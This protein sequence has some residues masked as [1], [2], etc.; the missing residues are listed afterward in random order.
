MARRRAASLF[1]TIAHPRCVSAFI[2]S[3][4]QHEGLPF[5]QING[6]FTIGNNGEG[7]LPQVGNSFQWSDSFTKVPVVT[8]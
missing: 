4:A 5:I 6:G 2:R 7:E 3:W 8:P 1:R